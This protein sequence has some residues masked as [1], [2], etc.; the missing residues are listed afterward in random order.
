VKKEDLALDAWL[1]DLAPSTELR[2]WF[3]HL[4][5]K[6]AEFRRRYCKELNLHAE[7]VRELVAIAVERDLTLVFGARDTNHN[8]AATLREYLLRKLRRRTSP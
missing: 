5:E 6:W 1:K 4:P 7:A 3:N 2:R 8:N